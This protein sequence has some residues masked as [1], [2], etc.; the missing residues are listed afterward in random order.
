M[1]ASRHYS[2]ASVG[3]M[4]QPTAETRF[5]AAAAL[6][7]ARL[8]LG[9]VTATPTSP[10]APLHL[11]ALR[12]AALATRYDKLAVRYD[13]TVQITNINTWLRDLSNRA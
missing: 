10:S 3:V 13:A 6:P 5:Q 2:S 12:N 8:S 4:Q 9:T 7:G 1:E 11:P